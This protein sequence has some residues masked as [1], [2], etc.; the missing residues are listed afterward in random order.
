MRERY[1]AP[2]SKCIFGYIVTG[3]KQQ[4]FRA[5]CLTDAVRHLFIGQLGVENDGNLF[6]L[7][8]IN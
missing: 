5:G 3:M 8:F 2:L 4:L 6:F 1:V 7:D